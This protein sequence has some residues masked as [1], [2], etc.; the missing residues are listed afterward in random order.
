[1]VEV[2]DAVKQAEKMVKTMGEVAAI[3]SSETLDTVS[4]I[5]LKQAR[6]KATVIEKEASVACLEARKILAGKQKTEDDALQKLQARLAVCRQEFTAL[7]KSVSGAEKLIK[8]KEVLRQG[9]DSF[10][11]AKEHVTKVV[12]M[13]ESRNLSDNDVQEIETCTGEAQ[14]ALKAVARCVDVHASVSPNALKTFFQSLT[15]KSWKLQVCVF[16][17]QFSQHKRL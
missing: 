11:L 10:R 7:R 5:A 13:S 1:M 8:S 14:K 17:L 6:K 2:I 3:F 15:D 16:L 9:M 12:A 4:P